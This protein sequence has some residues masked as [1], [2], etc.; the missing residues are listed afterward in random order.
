MPLWNW[1]EIGGILYQ[2]CSALVV[3]IRCVT[4]GPCILTQNVP[5]LARVESKPVKSIKIR[6]KLR[7]LKLV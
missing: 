7:I 4:S 2:S 3:K 1:A 5:A 6:S